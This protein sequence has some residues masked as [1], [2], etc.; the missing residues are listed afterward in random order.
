MKSTSSA[1][2]AGTM[3]ETGPLL[4]GV[5]L[6][7]SGVTATLVS[8]ER[9]IVASTSC[10]VALYS[11]FLGWAEADP[12]EWW[13]ATCEV[14]ARLLSET[15]A[16][17]ADVAA[18]SISGTA[19]AVV[20]C[21][22]DGTPLRR[23]ILQNDVRAT[24]E[25]RELQRSLEH[26]DLLQLT[27]SIL[28][29]Q[30]VAPTVLWLARNEPALWSRTVSVQG[31][32]DWLACHFGASPHVE[33][34]WALE[35]GLYDLDLR[36][37]DAVPAA[38]KITWPTLLPVLCSGAIAGEVTGRAAQSSG[39]REGTPIVVGGADH[40]L[41]AYGAGLVTTGDALIKL[42]GAGDILA[43]SQKVFLDRRL[44]LDAHP[45]PGA[46]LP[47][48]S[49]AT[50]G[51]VL[52]WE[53]ALFEGVSLDVLDQEARLSRPGALVSLPYFLGEKTPLHDPDLRGVIAGLHLGTTRGDLH[54]SFLEG[55]A[56]GFKAHV[57]VFVE[58]GLVLGDVRVTN[59]GSRSRLWRE[60]LADVLHHDLISILNHPGA[61]YGAAVIAGIGT[62]LIDD[63]NYVE[64]AL[65]KG[66]VIS[67]NPENVTIYE[68]RYQQF[69]QLSL[70][71]T[72][73]SHSLARS[74]P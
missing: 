32:Y 51:S 21:D 59:G 8:P 68:E 72:P 55:I 48:G 63:W 26:L 50:S 65:E 5:D 49:M 54:R 10:E 16:T 25:I 46:W 39:L 22:Q 64:G 13:R 23:A 60:I 35:S 62:G 69:L 27:G 37:L 73:I 11:D 43:V 9:G 38:T 66:E 67:P 33:Q 4:L 36:P 18:L 17:N 34:N 44:Y 53:Q 30:S 47:N 58:G 70:A 3:P 61:S 74:S 6:G 1:F 20:I 71:S 7:A 41:S 19:P 31:S 24:H 56:Y 45:I 2:S 12:H 40:V 14:I 15:G 57:D 42:G 29:Q 28:S 52:R